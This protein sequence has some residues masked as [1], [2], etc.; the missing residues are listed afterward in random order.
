MLVLSR[1]RQECIRIS[2]GVVVTVLGI[3]GG[4]VKLGIEAPQQMHVVRTELIT[5][6]VKSS[7]RAMSATIVPLA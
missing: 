4:I 6:S 3:H 5:A 2:D 1:K 7:D